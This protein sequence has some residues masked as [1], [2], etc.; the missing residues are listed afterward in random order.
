MRFEL[1]IVGGAQRGSE[2]KEEEIK[3]SAAEMDI[4]QFITWM[5]YVPYG[6]ELKAIYRDADIFILP[7]LTEG[8]PKVIYEAMAFG[9][10]IISTDVGGI[11]DIIKNNRNGILIKPEKTDDIVSAVNLLYEKP[12]FAKMLIEN[13]LNDAKKLTIESARQKILSII[14]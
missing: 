4:D 8:I 6:E 5:G 14:K 2:D 11:S 3:K 13:C 10:P 12:N 9:L 1:V 7:S